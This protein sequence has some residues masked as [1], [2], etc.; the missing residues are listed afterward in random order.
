M[1]NYANLF[2]IEGEEIVKLGQTLNFDELTQLV[3][4]LSGD[5]HNIFI[6]GCGTSAMVA[7]KSVHTLSVVG[8][9]AFYLNPSDAVHGSLGQVKAEDIVIFIS[10]GGSTK[11]LTSFVENVSDKKA[12]IVVV[13][14][15]PTAILAK[16]ADLVVKV[17]VEK[18]LDAFNMLATTSSLAVIALFDVV[19]TTLMQTENFSKND[20]LLNHPSG[21]VGQRLAVD[22]NHA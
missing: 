16:Q 2:K 19:A 7:R 14:E 8:K 5:E 6:T 11:E 4:L 10:K 20:F 12:K 1:S 13:T 9:P 21:E 22:V 3:E 17:K 15:N 18:E